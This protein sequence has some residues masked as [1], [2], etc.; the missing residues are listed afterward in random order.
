MRVNYRNI[1]WK[2]KKQRYK[3][4]PKSGMKTPTNSTCRRVY[5]K[6]NNT[7]VDRRNEKQST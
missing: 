7:K 5:E 2:R 6:Q 3:A 1:Q 4:Y